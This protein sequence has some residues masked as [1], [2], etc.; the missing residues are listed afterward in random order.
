VSLKQVSLKQVS[1]VLP[2]TDLL[3]LRDTLEAWR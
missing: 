3:S 1:I 2:L